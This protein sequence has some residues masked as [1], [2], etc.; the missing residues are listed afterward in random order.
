MEA[1][2]AVAIGA[3]GVV[4][5]G[6]N[7]VVGSGTLVTFPT[8]LAFGYPPVVANVSNNIGLVPGS[9]SAAYGYRRELR[10]QRGR[11]LRFAV[12][13]LIGGL[14]GSLLLLK[15][16]ESAFDAVLPVL[17]LT[18]CVLVLLQP[19]LNR[20]LS[21]RKRGPRHK[22]GGVPVWCGVLGTG[23]YGGY[24]GAAQ[25]VLMM[26]IFGAFLDEDLQRLN[27]VKNVL[28]S[29]VNGVAAVV[30]IIVAD[31][32]WA[33]AAVVAT[34]A[35]IGGLIGA[36]IGRKLS[37]TVLRGIIVAVGLTASVVVIVR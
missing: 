9:M 2:E 23:V 25:G 29:V 5:G 6:M 37:P 7:A 4:A 10:G 27:A 30:F 12:A 36:R 8:L 35:T 24:F 34:G 31:V 33:A 16:P 19:R 13:S 3:A 26:G 15:L 18:A 21:N 28:G 20:W 14:T 11:I 1:L 22:D 32:S 17:I